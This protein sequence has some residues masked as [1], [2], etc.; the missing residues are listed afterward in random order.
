MP[1]FRLVAASPVWYYSRALAAAKSTKHGSSQ[2]YGRHPWGKTPPTPASRYQPKI[3][4]QRRE[5]DRAASRLAGRCR[6]DHSG[7]LPDGE[8]RTPQMVA[9]GLRSKWHRKTVAMC[10]EPRL[11]ATTTDHVSIG[12]KSGVM[13]GRETVT[14]WPQGRGRGAAR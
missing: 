13:R 11:R 6:K 5:H 12:G 4:R 7:S 3:E 2:V 1:I 14:A 9:A 8:H 10:G